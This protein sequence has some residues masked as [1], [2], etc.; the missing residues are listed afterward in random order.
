MTDSK[1]ASEPGELENQSE[2]CLIFV[3]YTMRSLKLTNKCT[4]V[5]VV[6][7]S[8]IVQ[9]KS[10]YLLFPPVVLLLIATAIISSLATSQIPFGLVSLSRHLSWSAKL[11]GRCS[12][13]G[14]SGAGGVPGVVPSKVT[15]ALLKLNYSIA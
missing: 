3:R 8:S 9:L 2:L 7:F 11:S 14:A 12:E 15:L 13:G 10:E 4:E 5:F 1:Q 6:L